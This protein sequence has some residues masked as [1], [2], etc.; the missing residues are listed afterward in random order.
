M[1]VHYESY[2]VNGINKSFITVHYESYNVHRNVTMLQCY[3]FYYIC[4]TEFLY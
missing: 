2:N 1:T 3:L 4:D